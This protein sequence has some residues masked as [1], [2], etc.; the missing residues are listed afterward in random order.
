MTESEVRELVREELLRE[1]N[2][3]NSNHLQ[4]VIGD[5]L[6]DWSEELTQ[7]EK[8]V[9]RFLKHRLD[10]SYPGMEVSKDDLRNLL[11]HPDIRQAVSMQGPMQREEIIDTIWNT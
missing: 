5:L 11:K 4:R 7:P 2:T 9:Y 1:Q 6:D 10:Q 8:E 3:L